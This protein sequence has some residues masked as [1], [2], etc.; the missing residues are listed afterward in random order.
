M[1]TTSLTTTTS[2]TRTT[3]ETQVGFVS[4]CGGNRTADK[5]VALHFPSAITG[6]RTSGESVC[7]LTKP[8]PPPDAKHHNQFLRNH[9]FRDP[10]KL[11]DQFHALHNER[12]R[13][14]EF[15]DAEHDER[16]GDE[17]ELD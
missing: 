9:E 7:V 17:Y 1:T 5:R 12:D 11:D 4:F 13:D 16:D 8:S 15:S 10:N 2:A 3:S 6:A 14:D